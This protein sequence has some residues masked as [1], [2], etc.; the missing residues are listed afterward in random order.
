MNV[1]HHVSN[2]GFGT[3]NLIEA[4]ASATG[5]VV[6]RLLT[7]IGAPIT[8][9]VA[10]NLYAALF[11]DTGGF[12]HENT[13]EAA[14]RL[15]ADLVAAGANP[16]WVALKSYKSRSVPQIKLEGLAVARLHTEFEGRL[17]WSQITQE[18][19]DEAGAD[20][21]ESE[22]VIDQLQSID[23]MAIALLFKENSPGVTKVSVRTRD[24]YDATAVCTPFGGGGHHRA[25]GAE[26]REPLAV[27]EPRV[28][29][30]A[31]E[32][33]RSSHVTPAL[34]GP[35]ATAATHS[36]IL[37][38][39][40]PAGMTS[41]DA[42]RSVR[43]IFNERRVGHAGTLDPTATGLLP[44]CVGQATRLVDYF[45]QQTKT[46][47]CVVRF[48]EVS[49]TLDTEGDVVA[50]GDASAL[51][52]ADVRAAAAQFVGDIEQVPPMHSA[53]RHDGK[54]LYEL[55][56]NGQEVERKPR[57]AHI[58]SIELT[59]FRP[60]HRAEA[61]L[62]VVSGKGAYMRVL[63]ADIGERLGRRGAARLAGAHLVRTAGGRGRGHPG[64]ACRPPRSHRGTVAARQRGGLPASRRPR[65]AA[66]DDGG[67]WPVGLASARSGA[68]RGQPVP[69]AQ[70][71][72]T[73]HRHRRDRREPDASH[74]GSQLLDPCASRLD[75]AAGRT[76]T[77]L[78][79]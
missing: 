28:L 47:H 30:V 63:A 39:D 2:E 49:D 33:L 54:H 48:G 3:I 35:R 67:T 45:H 36:G 41:F 44:V 72:R 14:L 74:E 69:C 11:T 43:R 50:A 16:G 53:V 61:D 15:G 59:D 19:L 75:W 9:D 31:R 73:S 4:T 17:V 1:D 20:M 52:E 51:T 79:C 66:G 42:V 13:T 5:Q 65:R 25:A 68:H 71:R 46:Y 78:W 8:A 70:R 56:R 29:D 58:E 27:F 64:C 26:L 18:M 7:S 38:I 24:P 57:L 77:H 12:R 37:A 60:G 21:M 23:T 76:P 10:T 34:A 22:G 40:K 6:H 55:A 62:I 32:L